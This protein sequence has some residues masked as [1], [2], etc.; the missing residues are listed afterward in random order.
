AKIQLYDGQTG[1]PK[2]GWDIGESKGMFAVAFSADGQSLVSACGPVK[3]WDV[4]TGKERKTLETKGTATHVAVSPGGRYLA[5]WSFPME[6]D[7]Y[8]VETFLW[9]AKT[10]DLKRTLPWHDPS[11][12][13]S[14]LAF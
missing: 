9:D 7:K 1:E 2:Q 10:G 8:I 5:T 14:S 12:W 3:L 4:R 13:T 6:N 11:L